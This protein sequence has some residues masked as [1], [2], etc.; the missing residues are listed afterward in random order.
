MGLYVASECCDVKN[1]TTSQFL[2]FLFFR[3]IDYLCIWNRENNGFLIIQ[4]AVPQVL[5]LVSNIGP[6]DLSL[7]LES[8]FKY[9]LHRH[10]VAS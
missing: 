8:G 5:T 1:A 4:R 10:T 7:T 9:G 2:Y 3:V 6:P